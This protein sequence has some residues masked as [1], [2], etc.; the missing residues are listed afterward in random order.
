M[1]T[2]IVFLAIFLL[3]FSITFILGYVIG[4]AKDGYG[5]LLGLAAGAGI[6]NAVM[7]TFVFPR[8]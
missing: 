7:H 5:Y 6:G 1:K 8:F 4:L 3:A 2:F